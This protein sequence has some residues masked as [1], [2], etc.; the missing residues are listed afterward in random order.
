LQRLPQHKTAPAWRSEEPA[1]R[2]HRSTT[3]EGDKSMTVVRH[4]ARAALPASLLL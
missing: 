1:A 2:G 4:L 3:E